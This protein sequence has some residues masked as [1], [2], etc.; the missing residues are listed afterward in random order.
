MAFIGE[1]MFCSA[2][3]YEDGL[4]DRLFEYDLYE[5]DVCELV[6]RL[7]C[8]EHNAAIMPVRIIEVI[9]AAGASAIK[10]AFLDEDFTEMFTAE[11]I[12]ENGIIHFSD[13]E[14]SGPYE[15]IIHDAGQS[16]LKDYYDEE[17]YDQLFV[18][19]SLMK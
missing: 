2:K 1:G 8:R 9:E 16:Y 18:L 19:K 6:T 12:I 10:L 14:V 4:C 15:E 17:Y 7:G 5:D 11:E 13:L 3:E